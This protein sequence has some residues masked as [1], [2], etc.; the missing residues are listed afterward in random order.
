MDSVHNLKAHIKLQDFPNQI[1][2]MPLNNYYAYQGNTKFK[3]PDQVMVLFL[4]H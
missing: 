3:T 2:L 4:K 1:I